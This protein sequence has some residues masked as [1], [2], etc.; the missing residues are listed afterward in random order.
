ML[1]DQFGRIHDYLRISL[2]D[3]CNFRCLYCLPEPE[4]HNG[5]HSDQMTAEE[6]VAIAK[7]FLK[8]GVTKIRITGGEPL[9]RKDAGEI[10]DELGKLDAKLVIT[11]NGARVDK[12]LD[13]FIRSG[14]KSVNISLDSL[15]QETFF[16]LTGRN[17]F[18]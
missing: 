5:C 18:E 15:S 7:E 11:T 10:I 1:K 12:F 16:K 14:I 17:E 13:N 3:R 2:T 4:F 6:I 9:V 8:A